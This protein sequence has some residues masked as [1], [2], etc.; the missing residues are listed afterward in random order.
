MENMFEYATRNKLRFPSS[1][2]ELPV[3]MLWDVPLRH[4]TD[5]NLDSIAK[6]ANK[7]LKDLSEES[8]VQPTR[9]VARE[10]AEVILALVKHV[11]EVK[12]TEEAAAKAKADK[13]VEKEK[14]LR[15]LAEKQDGLLSAL[16]VEELQK[17]IAAL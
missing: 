4:A 13:R 8:F 2:G 7:A 11:I 3:E 16:T 5:F 17:K 6:A 14:L 15:V 12:L 9:T 10:R 1:R